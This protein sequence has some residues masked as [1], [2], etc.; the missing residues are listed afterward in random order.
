[1]RK[2]GSNKPGVP[3]CI[4][5]AVVNVGKM[6][7]EIDGRVIGGEKVYVIAEI[8]NN[9]NGSFDKAIHMI[10]LIKEWDYDNC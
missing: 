1:M 4:T 2:N 10:Q 7:F 5:G 9:H 6:K 8:G 3:S